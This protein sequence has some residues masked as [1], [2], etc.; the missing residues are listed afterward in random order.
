MGSYFDYNGHIC[1]LFDLMGSSIFDFLVS[2]LLQ[3]QV[4]RILAKSFLSAN[5]LQKANHYKPYPM[6]QT[7]HITWQLCNAV[8]FLHDNK[9]TH[10]DL[11]PENI[12]FVDSR[13]TTKLV[14]KKVGKFVLRRF[15]IDDCFQPLRVLHSTH[16]RLIDF[17]SATFDHEHHSII[18]STR[19]YRAP[20]VILGKC[21]IIYTIHKCVAK[22]KKKTLA[23]LL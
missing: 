13:Y 19:H 16:V 20:E 17:G 4:W 12:L 8:K 3:V 21:I 10:T 23:C 5:F 15:K 9:L 18:V 22:S 14:D 7:L 6:E 2:C 1:L 11:K